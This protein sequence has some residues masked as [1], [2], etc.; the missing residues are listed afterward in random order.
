MQ[1]EGGIEWGSQGRGVSHCDIRGCDVSKLALL[2][3]Q[4]VFGTC[5]WRPW[6][7][8]S[9]GEPMAQQG[10]GSIK[11]WLITV[12]YNRCPV[13]CLLCDLLVLIDGSSVYREW[14]GGRGQ[15]AVLWAS[16]DARLV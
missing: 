2:I 10:A 5:A 16:V 13:H 4:F 9:A 6:L 1:L 8:H 3:H 7:S 11:G 14:G 12:A 15:R